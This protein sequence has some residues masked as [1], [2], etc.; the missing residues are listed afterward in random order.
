M[1]HAI[2]GALL[3]DHGMPVNLRDALPGITTTTS[4]P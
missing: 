3:H 4:G 2:T 1:T